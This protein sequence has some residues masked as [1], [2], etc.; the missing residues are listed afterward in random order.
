MRWKRGLKKKI[1]L[2]SFTVIA[3]YLDRNL[4]IRRLLFKLPY[5]KVT[6]NRLNLAFLPY[7]RVQ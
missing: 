1:D 7:F 4:G 6:N 3:V 2:K 5:P